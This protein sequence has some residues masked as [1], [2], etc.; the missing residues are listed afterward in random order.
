MKFICDKST[1]FK[2][3]ST[4]HEIIVSKNTISILANI[5]LEAENDCLIIRSSDIKIN[6]TTK[7]PVSVLEKGSITV[8]SDTF[9]HILGSIPEGEIEFETSDI[10]MTIKPAFKKLKFNLRTLSAEQ[11]PPFPAAE[12]V[13]FFEL[14]AAD[15][16]D[17]INQ[18]VFSVS[19]DE[20]RYFMNGVY[21]EKAGDKFISVATDGRRMAYFEKEADSSLQD[22]KGV[23][24]PVK[25]LNTVVKRIGE[26]GNVS[27]G[28]NDKYI[29]I[30][31][32]SY[33][34]AGVLIEGQFPNYR[35]VIPENQKYECKVDRIEVLDA[36]KRISLLVEKKAKRIFFK[37]ADNTIQIYTDEGDEGDANEELSCEYSG[38]SEVLIPLNYT[39]IEEPFA[40]MHTKKV[41]I[42]FTEAGKALTIKP[43]DE[44]NLFHVVM[45]MQSE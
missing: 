44:P 30:N 9:L 21:F 5:Y 23:I 25:I 33:S 38:T 14:S 36:V 40:V 28:I 39:H 6:F 16:K 3:I 17:M 10:K 7:V 42:S 19:D 18:T 37:I 12:D 20:T 2:E 1:L 4:A 31:F 8:K 15:F 35:K 45:P 41:N 32:G 26:E 34:F 13:N 11:Y 29:F 24:I 27:I 43:E 22:I